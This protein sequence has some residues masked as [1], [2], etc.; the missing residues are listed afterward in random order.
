MQNPKPVIG[1]KVPGKRWK[2]RAKDYRDL[3]DVPVIYEILEAHQGRVRC[4]TTIVETGEI[5]ETLQGADD[6]PRLKIDGYAE[7][8]AERGE[9]YEGHYQVRT[10]RNGDELCMKKAQGY[11]FCNDCLCTVLSYVYGEENF[12]GYEHNYCFRDGT[13]YEL[14]ETDT[15]EE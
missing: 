3:V 9:V 1:L 7:I 12:T 15:F 13:A 14:E 2:M 11:N 5:W 6:N 8:Y 10:W 4:R